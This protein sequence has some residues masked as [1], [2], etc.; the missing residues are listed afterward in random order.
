ME[1]EQIYPKPGDVEHDPEAIWQ[2]QLQTAREAL[3]RANVGPISAIGITNQRE[4]TVLWD[5]HTGQAVANAIVWQSRVS[6]YDLR[7]PEGAGHE[8]LF[9]RKTGLVLDAYF[10]GT[11]IA[12]LLATVPACGRAPRRARSSSAPSTHSSS[13]VSPAD[14][15]T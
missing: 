3:T 4:T 12:H 7:T 1:F 13:G 8:P 6:A 5:R 11:K 9:R 14:A 15:C 10:S 2:T